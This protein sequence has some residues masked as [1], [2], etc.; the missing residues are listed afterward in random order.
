VRCPLRRG[1][2]LAGCHGGPLASLGRLRRAWAP[3]LRA[4]P[5]GTPELSAG[6]IACCC[7][8]T[9]P[10]VPAAAAAATTAADAPPRPAPARR[11]HHIGC[12]IQVRG[13]VTRRTGVFP[14]LSLVKYDC[15]KCGYV[16]GPFAQ[17][18]NREEKPQS[19]PNCQAKGPFSLNTLETIY[20]WARRPPQRAGLT[21]TPGAQAE[22][23]CG[24][25]A[26][27]PRSGG[28]PDQPCPTTHCSRA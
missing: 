27:R 7:R 11:I 6:C 28:G 10:R 23:H 13:V 20:R 16:L 19:C 12:L 3:G 26:P 1:S 15:L 8:C 18:G 4:T 5:A 14:Q 25:P 24:R 21:A 22:A 9:P 2:G 17:N